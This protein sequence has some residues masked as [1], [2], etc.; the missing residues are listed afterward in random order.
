MRALEA[1][2]ETEGRKLRVR[3]Q[4]VTGATI[5]I[6]I[7][8]AE[9]M[10]RAEGD[11]GEALADYLR[12]ALASAASKWQLAFTIRTDNFPELQS[13]RRFQDLNARGYD[14]RAYR[15]FAL[16]TWSRS[17]RNATASRSIMHSSMR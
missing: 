16:R 10:A 14:L 8:Q 17:R 12:A 6:S 4:T 1:A 13:H 9:E 5:L 7:D 15:Y 2:L 11:S 3:P